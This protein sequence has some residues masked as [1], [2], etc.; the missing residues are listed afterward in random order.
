MP[1]LDYPRSTGRGGAGRRRR[2]LG[3]LGRWFPVTRATPYT[4]KPEGDKALDSPEPIVIYGARS[5]SLCSTILSATWARGRV[6]DLVRFTHTRDGTE[7]A[8]TLAGAPFAVV[9]SEQVAGQAR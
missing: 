2:T 4:L 7:A 8:F 6:A 9:R 3:T 5:T 1:P